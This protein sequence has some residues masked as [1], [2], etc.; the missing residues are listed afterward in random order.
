MTLIRAS[1]LYRGETLD[2]IKSYLL[3]NFNTDLKV[4][5]KEMEKNKVI[6]SKNIG[7]NRI[8]VVALCGTLNKIHV[9]LVKSPSVGKYILHA[10]WEG[11]KVI[12]FDEK[13]KYN[14]LSI[15]YY[16]RR[17]ISFRKL[18]RILNSHGKII[19][20]FDEVEKAIEGSR[21]K[22]K[23]SHP[24]SKKSKIVSY[25]DVIYKNKIKDKFNNE[26]ISFPLKARAI[27]EDG[28]H[29]ILK[30][31][32]TVLGII[33]DGLLKG[34]KLSYG[35]Y[36]NGKVIKVT[37]KDVKYDGKKYHFKIN[38]KEFSTIK[39]K[40]LIQK[41]YD[42]SFQFCANQE[43][44]EDKIEKIIEEENIKASR[45]SP[46]RTVKIYLRDINCEIIFELIKEDEWKLSIDGYNLPIKYRNGQKLIKFLKEKANYYY[47]IKIGELIPEISKYVEKPIEEITPILKSIITI[48][49]S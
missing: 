42:K 24:I 15:N 39:I 18:K 1:E 20:T 30:H 47:D 23:E 13:P 41:I 28:H 26:C 4:S 40:K 27:L 45:K 7:K 17:N 8:I 43:Q 29:Y 48:K 38:D 36:K 35:K 9:L 19:H 25:S 2:E 16:N 10:N 34:G 14:N 32:N 33:R 11:T 44:V 46:E 21:K 49:R 31:K 5:N 37:L 22:P 12:T 6:F 3:F